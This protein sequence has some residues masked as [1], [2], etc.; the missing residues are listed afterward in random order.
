M[1][2]MTTGLS[3]SGGSV[4]IAGVYYGAEVLTFVG[5]I[6]VAVATVLLAR[7]ERPIKP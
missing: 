1:Y 6:L 4:I 5:A 2:G 7:P 3:A